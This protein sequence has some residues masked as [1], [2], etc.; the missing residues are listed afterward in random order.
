MPRSGTSMFGRLQL[1]TGYE[2]QQAE[3]ARKRKLA[4]AM[5][6]ASMRGGPM[7]SWAQPLGR[8]AQ[9][10]ASTRLNK[11]ADKT[12][13]AWREQMR[14][15]YAQKL[16]EINQD[17]QSMSTEEVVRKWAGDPYVREILDPY[18][19]AMANQLQEAN[20]MVKSGD[21]WVRRGDI[22]AGELVGNKMGDKV[23]YDSE[24]NAT[25]NPVAVNAALA[26]QG[27]DTNPGA[28]Q[29]MADPRAGMV[30]M[31]RLP[32]LSPEEKSLLSNLPKVRPAPPPDGVL[33]SGKPYWI[34]NGVPSPTPPGG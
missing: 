31:N 1:P 5:M 10:F 14:N 3:A 12:D 23:I 9:A 18:Q 20:D 27:F 19:K 8:I 28:P 26:A 25:I 2:E 29:T 22:R 17:L 30:G 33:S 4:D 13:S 7:T 34:I 32:S 6:Q 16:T 15:T 11:K 24:G 21:R